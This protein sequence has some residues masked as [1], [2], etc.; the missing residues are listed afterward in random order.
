MSR[1][2]GYIV[3]LLCVSFLVAFG[4]LY[5][6]AKPAND[7]EPVVAEAR[8]TQA[9]EPEIEDTGTKEEVEAAALE[10]SAET[11]ISVK[12]EESAKIED[13]AVEE[14]KTPTEMPVSPYT[15]YS[16]TSLNVRSA[17]DVSASKQFVLSVN[18]TVTVTAEVE[19]GWVAVTGDKGSGYCNKAYLGTEQIPE[20]EPVEDIW[21]VTYYNN[22]G[23]AEADASA[24]TQW[25][26]GYFIAHS[27]NANGKR[28]LSKPAYVVVDG[29]KYRY[30]SCKYV[31]RDTTYDESL[32]AWVHANGGIAFQTCAGEPYLILHYEP[33]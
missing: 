20:P 30:V 13:S 28:I 12:T 4:I 24:V 2:I 19:N 31:S 17:P 27:T 22:Y 9:E 21:Y 10:V 29:Q 16:Q 8:E 23:S 1:R 26:D 6:T 5:M 14:P 7:W 32:Q 15:M 25:A 33:V 18:D 3:G 11:A